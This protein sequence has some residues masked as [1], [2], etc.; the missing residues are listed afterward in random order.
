[1]KKMLAIVFAALGALVVHALILMFGGL[2]ASPAASHRGTE[3]RNVE[4]RPG[5]KPADRVPPTRAAQQ[6]K[7]AESVATVEEPAKEP[8]AQ[9]DALLVAAEVGGPVAAAAVAGSAESAPRAASSARC[10]SL[11]MSA[12]AKPPS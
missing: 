10:R 5:R 3:V 9:A 7:P 6:P 2:L 1:M 11:I 12:S 4:L 8:P